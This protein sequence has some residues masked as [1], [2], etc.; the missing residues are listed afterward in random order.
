MIDE[1][2]LKVNPVL[3]GSGI[4][5]F[6]GAIQQSALHLV[7]SKAYGN[8]SSSSVIGW[9]VENMALVEWS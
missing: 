6:A 5:L 4:P 2:V 1:L 8:G 3:F 7:D 9:A